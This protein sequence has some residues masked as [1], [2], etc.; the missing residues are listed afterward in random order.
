[1]GFSCVTVQLRRS[2]FPKR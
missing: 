2:S 1:M